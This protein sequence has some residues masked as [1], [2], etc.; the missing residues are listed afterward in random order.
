MAASDDLHDPELSA[1]SFRCLSVME[2]LRTRPFN[3]VLLDFI[4]TVFTDLLNTDVRPG[5]A[6]VSF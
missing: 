3:F 2:S 1:D 6:E 4:W 5:I